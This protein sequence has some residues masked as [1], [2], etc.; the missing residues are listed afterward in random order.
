MN[1]MFYFSELIGKSSEVA[2][3]L[4]EAKREY[5]KEKNDIKSRARKETVE[6]LEATRS[7][8]ARHVP[9]GKSI[10]PGDIFQPLPRKDPEPPS[11]MT[12]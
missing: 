2:R 12:H 10:A 9:L 11:C 8:I 4:E 3:L 7:L 1:L 6:A 5:E